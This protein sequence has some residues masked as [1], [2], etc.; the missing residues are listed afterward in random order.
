Y[1]FLPRAQ[2]SQSGRSVRWQPGPL[3]MRRF[4]VS[5]KSGIAALAGCRETQAVCHSEEPQATRNLAR[6]Y[7]QSE[8]P[9]FARNDSVRNRFSASCYVRRRSLDDEICNLPLQVK[10]ELFVP[11]GWRSLLA[12]IIEPVAAA[13]I[14]HQLQQAL[15]IF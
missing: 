11:A 1:S 9:R 4:V 7:F 13:Q 10:R 2:S 15:L 3:C 12:S 5:W 6:P 14:R 8:I